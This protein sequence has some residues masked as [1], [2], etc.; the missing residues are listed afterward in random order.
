MI[1]IWLGHRFDFVEHPR[2]STRGLAF[3]ST[4]LPSMAI[5]GRQTPA[6]CGVFW[7]TSIEGARYPAEGWGEINSGRSQKTKPSKNSR[8]SD[9]YRKRVPT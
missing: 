8:Q 6:L 1:R 7:Y 5:Y 2:I 3:L 9:R 4:G